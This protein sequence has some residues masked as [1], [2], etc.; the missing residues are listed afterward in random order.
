[1][2][3]VMNSNSHGIAFLKKSGG[4]KTDKFNYISFL[5]QMQILKK[6]L[7]NVG[8][9]KGTV[10]EV[11]NSEFG[12]YGFTIIYRTKGPKSRLH[13]HQ[14]I[15]KSYDPQKLILLQGKMHMNFVS[16]EGEKQELLLEQGDYI[17][18]PKNI[19]HD[20]KCLEDSI[21]LEQREQKYDKSNADVQYV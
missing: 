13:K 1:M 5:R 8:N 18:I 20:Y 17:E 19:S 6:K 7:V 15:D 4:Q 16:E 2:I 14:G 11:I 12:E 10:Y 9:E 21:F 3:Q